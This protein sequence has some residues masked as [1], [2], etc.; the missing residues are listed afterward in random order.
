MTDYEL[1]AGSPEHSEAGFVT[2]KPDYGLLTQ[3]AD[4]FVSG[5]NDG[6]FG[7][8]LSTIYDKALFELT[9][10]SKI[11]PRY[12]DKD[13]FEA[14]FPGVPFRPGITKAEASSLAWR[15]IQQTESYLIQ[16]GSRRPLSNLA[17]SFV[18][19]ALNPIDLGISVLTGGG[20][21]AAKGAAAARSV[22]YLRV[23]KEAAKLG[24]RDALWQEPFVAWGMKLRG[25]DY[26]P[27]DF[28]SSVF[29]GGAVSGL[30]GTGLYTLSRASQHSRAT[31]GAITSL[32]DDVYKGQHDPAIFKNLL[33]MDRDVWS[34]AAKRKVEIDRLKMDASA[35]KIFDLFDKAPDEQKSKVQMEL[36]VLKE[37][38]EASDLPSAGNKV[39]E[40]ITFDELKKV[41]RDVPTSEN[42]RRLQSTFKHVFRKNILFVD[43]AI[44]D[45]YGFSGR[46]YANQADTI[47][48]VRRE[49]QTV[50]DM[51]RLAGHEL[52]HAIRSSAPMAWRALMQYIATD[53]VAQDQFSKAYFEAS[54]MYGEA[55]RWSSLSQA[56][57]I[58]E[59][60]AQLVSGASQHK[61]FWHRISQDN[62]ALHT[63]IVS[64]LKQFLDRMLASLRFQQRTDPTN[65]KYLSKEIAGFAGNVGHILGTAVD[66]DEFQKLLVEVGPDE[67]LRRMYQNTDKTKSFGQFP[68]MG[69]FR[70]NKR[71]GS[72]EEAVRPSIAKASIEVAAAM[73]QIDRAVDDLIFETNVIYPFESHTITRK[74]RNPEKFAR[75]K[76][77]SWAKNGVVPD[78]VTYRRIE[79]PLDPTLGETWYEI[80]VYRNTD[81]PG[82][83][84]F[85][86]TQEPDPKRM[87]DTRTLP[88]N[89]LFDDPDIVTEA[90]F[91][92]VLRELIGDDKTFNSEQGLEWQGHMVR[93]LASYEDKT[94]ES[95]DDFLADF[96]G[97]LELDG[98]QSPVSG[99]DQIHAELS[100]WLYSSETN[101]ITR[102]RKVDGKEEK[103]E[104]KP[105][106]EERRKRL[107][108]RLDVWLKSRRRGEQIAE[109]SELA[110]L[111]SSGDQVP[112]VPR[113]M[114]DATKKELA[115]NLA[116]YLRNYADVLVDDSLAK[117][118]RLSDLAT[119][120]QKLLD[121]AGNQQALEE[122]VSK[123]LMDEVERAAGKPQDLWTQSKER[124][125]L[126][127][128]MDEMAS[129]LPAGASYE[130]TLNNTVQQVTETK[131]RMAK[132]AQDTHQRV[133]DLLQQTLTKA[134]PYLSLLPETYTKQ[135]DTYYYRL[136]G[137]ERKAFQVSEDGSAKKMPNLNKKQQRIMNQIQLIESRW[138]FLAES[139]DKVRERIEKLPDEWRSK[140]SKRWGDFLENTYVLDPEAKAEWAKEIQFFRDIEVLRYLKTEE[141]VAHWS[142]QVK[143]DIG[144]AVSALDGNFR[145]GR[146]GEGLSVEKKQVAR[147]LED[148]RALLEEIE[149]HGLEPFWKSGELAKAVVD[150]LE[151]GRVNQSLSPEI[152]QAVEKIAQVLDNTHK[153][154]V[155]RINAAGGAVTLREGFA[156]HTVHEPFRIRRDMD[157]WTAWWLENA[158]WEKM[159]REQG[160]DDLL[161]RKAQVAYL[162]AARDDILNLHWEEGMEFDPNVM[163]GNEARKASFA[164]RLL[165]KPGTA[166]DYDMSF[167]SG[168]TPS[169]IFSQLRKRSEVSVI[170][171][172]FGPNHKETLNRIKGEAGLYGGSAGRYLKESLFEQ[173]WLKLSGE[174]DRPVNRDI[175]TTGQLVRA[176]ANVAMLWKQV[177]ASMTDV[178]FTVSTMRWAG[179]PLEH[180]IRSV[181]GRMAEI[182]KAGP[183]DPKTVWLRGQ[184]AG[185][186]ALSNSY[187]RI[188]GYDSGSSGLARKANDFLFK[189][190]GMNFWNKTI[191]GAALDLLTQ[192]L[193]RM[194]KDGLNEAGARWL[195]L[196]GISEEEW[197][198]MAKYAGA[199]DGLDGIRLGLEM[200]PDAELRRKLAVAV[201][202]T[203]TY[204]VLEPSASDQAILRFATKPG[205]VLGEAI[206]SMMQY[207]SIP[208]AIMRKGMWRFRHGYG[209]GGLFDPGIL[210][211]RINESQ[212]AKMQMLATMFVIGTVSQGIRDVLRGREPVLWMQRDQWTASNLLRTVEAAGSFGLLTDI[213][214]VNG[215]AGPVPGTALK[216]MG[217]FGDNN[218]FYQQTNAVMSLTPGATLPIYDEARKALLSTIF[219]DAYG[220][221]LDASKRR[222]ETERGQSSL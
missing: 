26:G 131:D 4:S 78:F 80:R 83:T 158:D 184:G 62:P 77:M 74:L 114:I 148:S 48:L 149:L 69:G 221:W 157:G 58:D 124:M 68:I 102:W 142:K 118:F 133:L 46:V 43:E 164:R 214:D 38:G 196:Y 33:M 103:F 121:F 61:E 70:I 3:L 50:S 210:K 7:G 132:Y 37:A 24:V 31:R 137:A 203:M 13:K 30:L 96:S 75:E 110:R 170:M 99:F 90:N 215:L 165:M 171:E 112:L 151:S 163:G 147:W 179:V 180:G 111:L 135:V 175:A 88:K 160:R 145:T 20:A 219:A 173:T 104:A 73:D 168:D 10:G 116:K 120:R 204:A 32:V 2:P 51:T 200:I 15:D 109:E 198:S 172:E 126:D 207:K 211:G 21:V 217:A 54:K 91:N 167:G 94:W 92:E 53:A 105:L 134:Q 183:N 52:G 195:K 177:I 162:E 220:T 192:N 187:S 117:K 14:D 18:G 65:A 199:V 17:A 59:A 119:A 66:G 67:A 40:R 140:V 57:R 125:S 87:A 16:S 106:P 8:A 123:H 44:G 155:A 93:F 182:V 154:Q 76:I 181:F 143:D 95:L 136:L 22:R 42:E 193:G 27:E 60:M 127:E 98:V 5:Y 115:D 56:K 166:F 194:A 79:G 72:F 35:G 156:F 64:F 202:D 201:N 108:E 85:R 82:W 34:N 9:A 55:G 213:M 86:P 81:K 36:D 144:G 101:S 185:L 222:L 129:D 209:D 1:Y 71:V 188:A 139:P 89:N 39:R 150:R 84:E 97:F 19:A 49:G 28:A 130:E 12:E 152:A 141:R 208:L 45:K 205:T 159:S 174:T 6:S 218:Q 41:S 190:N 107:Q 25:D 122:F 189:W 197:A 191:Q 128:L 100:K 113:E 47:F 146:A 169:L 212:M 153:V 63:R 176:A 29:L 178:G 161:D 138:D 23:A 11:N 206:R 186:T 216:F